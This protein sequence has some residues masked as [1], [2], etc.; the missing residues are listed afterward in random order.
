LR[1][2][3]ALRDRNIELANKIADTAEQITITLENMQ[4]I[5]SKG[6]FQ[7]DDE[8]GSIFAE[9]KRELKTLSEI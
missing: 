7:A 5:D 4:R 6:A 2:V 9:L 8:V 1:K 3:E